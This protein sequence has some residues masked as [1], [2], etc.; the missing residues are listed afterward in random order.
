M[1]E[2]DRGDDE[3]ADDVVV[4]DDLLLV[5]PLSD[6]GASSVDSSSVSAAVSAAVAS[7][8]LIAPS[9]PSAW[10]V[11]IGRRRDVLLQRQEGEAVGVVEVALPAREREEEER[12]ADEHQAHE[13]LQHQDVHARLLGAREHDGGEDGRE[14]A[15]GHEHGAQ[16]R[17][18]QAGETKRD[19]E[20]VVDDRDG[21]V[22]AHDAREARLARERGA[23]RAEARA[24]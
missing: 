21:E 9:S 24:S 8:A 3:L 7:L 6:A 20:D 14:R 13:D 11:E 23:N 15:H 18:H 4:V 12:A 2:Q 17:R 16:Q 1:P 22:R 10:S 19:G 5:S